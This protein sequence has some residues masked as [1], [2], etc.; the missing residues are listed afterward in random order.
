[1]TISMFQHLEP[2][3]LNIYNHHSFITIDNKRFIF[4]EHTKKLERNRVLQRDMKEETYLEYENKIKEQIKNITID[5]YIV[6]D[7]IFLFTESYG[8]RNICH[9]MTEQLMVLNHFIHLLNIRENPN[10]HLIILINKNRRESMKNM[11]ID[12]V[13]S[14]PELKT[15]EILEYDLSGKMKMICCG[16]IFLSDALDCNLTNIY[17]LWDKLHSRLQ[18]KKVS[19]IIPIKLYM[20]RRNIY[21]PGKI[22]IQEYWK[23]M[24]TYQIKL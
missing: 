3:K 1:M 10:E 13:K 11:I 15:E 22:P 12:Y 24:R 6:K 18:I 8:D 5:D 19:N 23:I 20:S 2:C 4:N 21:Q 16:T 9:W 17:P 7:R 14:I